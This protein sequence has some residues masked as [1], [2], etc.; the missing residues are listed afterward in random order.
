MTSRVQ[1]VVVAIEGHRRRGRV[2]EMSYGGEAGEATDGCRSDLT[3]DS[4]RSFCGEPKT[5]PGVCD[6]VWVESC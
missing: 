6:M 3:R 5:D 1:E 4:F 2:L